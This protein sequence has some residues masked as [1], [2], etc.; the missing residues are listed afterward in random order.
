MKNSAL[1]FRLKN[2]IKSTALWSIVLFVSVLLILSLSVTD[3]SSTVTDEQQVL[4]EDIIR[5]SAVQCYAIEG[6]YPSDL[7]YLIDNYGLYYNKED[8]AVHYNNVGGNL[9]PEI[10]VFYLSE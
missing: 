8:F 5:R 7:Q 3:V 9:L 4:I 6:S 10:K 2:L 1:L